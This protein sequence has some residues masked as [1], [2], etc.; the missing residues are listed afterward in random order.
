MMLIILL[1]A[2]L[3]LVT[4]ALSFVLFPRWTPWKRLSLGLGVFL[5]LS[6]TL[7]G[8]IYWEAY[9]DAG[10]RPV[11]QEELREAATP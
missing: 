10:G 3:S 4:G 11:S 8:L 7:V 9:S 2:A 5:S 1:I 6:L